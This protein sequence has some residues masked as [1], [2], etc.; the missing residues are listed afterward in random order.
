MQ[1]ASTEV[2]CNEEWGLRG[3][4]LFIEKCLLSTTFVTG[5]EILT[6]KFIIQIPDLGELIFTGR[7][8]VVVLENGMDN[9]STNQSAVTEVS[10]DLRSGRQQN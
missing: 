6:Q 1:V 10:I 5:I 9:F 2:I 3:L 4:H 7:K 8:V